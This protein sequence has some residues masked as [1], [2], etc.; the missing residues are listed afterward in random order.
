MA[1][2]E[3]ARRSIMINLHY[4]RAAIEANTGFRLSLSRVRELLVEEGLIT[5]KQ[6]EEDAALFTGYHDFFSSDEASAAAYELDTE[7]GLP[8]RLIPGA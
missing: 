7:M 6:A 1:A 8:D 5:K 3:A 2:R 4:I